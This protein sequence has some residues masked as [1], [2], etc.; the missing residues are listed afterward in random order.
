MS[1]WG[2]KMDSDQ[3]FGAQAMAMNRV[4]FQPGMS[5]STFFDL[6]GSEPQCEVALVAARWPQGFVCPHCAGTAHCVLRVRHRQTFQCLSCRQQTSII[7]G[8]LFHST[9]LALR[10]WFLALYLL[11]QA[12]TNLS[13]LSLM[14]S[15]G[16]SYPT[17]WLIKHKVMQSMLERE[18]LYTLDGRVEVDDA[19]LGGERTGGKVGRGS[20][21]KAPFVAAVATT[22]SGAARRVKLSPVSGFT[23]KAVAGCQAQPGTRGQGHQRRPGLL[24]RRHRGRLHTRAVCGRTTQAQGPAAVQRDQHHPGQLENRH[25]RHLSRVR[26]LQVRPSLPRRIR[27]PLQSPLRSGRLDPAADRRRRHDQTSP[28]ASPAVG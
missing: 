7:A 27:L 10:T 19:Y 8:T 11:G 9:K 2:R 15:L 23:S 28:G 13:A 18:A 22:D 1:Q 26:L 5:M 24:C 3:I 25:R 14:R 6:Y 16:A 12:K 4:Q 20:E 21:N 17:A